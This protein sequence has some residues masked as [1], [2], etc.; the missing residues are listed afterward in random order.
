MGPL[1]GQILR[2][3]GRHGSPDYI[4]GGPAW[5]DCPHYHTS[6]LPLLPWR[7]EYGVGGP[8]ALSPHRP[9][10]V[11]RVHPKHAQL[12][13]L[14]ACLTGPGGRVK[15]IPAGPASG[16]G[17]QP[18]PVRGPRRTAP[19]GC[20]RTARAGRTRAGAAGPWGIPRSTRRIWDQT[21]ATRPSARTSCRG[22]RFSLRQVL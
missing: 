4:R 9:V 19:G 22:Q 17:S 13:G 8:S 2:E 12:P 1:S 20:P 15:A 18:L 7:P 6:S 21:R 5:A 3:T 11:L 10:R 16:P 14:G